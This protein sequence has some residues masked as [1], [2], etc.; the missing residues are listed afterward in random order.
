M[1]FH[2]RYV[3]TLKNLST[4]IERRPHTVLLTLSSP[5]TS[6]STRALCPRPP[7]Q[8]CKTNPGPYFQEKGASDWKLTDGRPLMMTLRWR[9][10]S[11]LRHVLRLRTVPLM[12]REYVSH[13]SIACRKGHNVTPPS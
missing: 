11:F 12:C 2:R 7:C 10:Q 8:G 4:D 3:D 9:G 13:I 1:C 6:T 5:F